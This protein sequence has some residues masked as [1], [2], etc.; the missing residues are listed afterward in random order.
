MGTVIRYSILTASIIGIAVVLLGL[1]NALSP[2]DSLGETSGD[3]DVRN[4]FPSTPN[5]TGIVAT[6]HSTGCAIALLSTQFTTYVYVHRAGEKD[7]PKSL[8]FRFFNSDENF[9]DP[10]IVWTDNSNVH[11]SIP[12][13][14]E[15]TKHLTS[16]DGVKISYAIGKEEFSR[17]E[18]RKY[19]I[20]LAAGL[21]VLLIF[22]TG[23]C[24][25]TVR[26]IRK[27]K[28]KLIEASERASR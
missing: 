18:D 6:G 24:F 4:D 14:G 3:C 15:V 19:T 25:L 1:F 27:Q 13:V 12:E 16:I 8:V 26:S 7:S 10:H 22:L 20:M 17:E 11:I 5:G 9:D 23:S 28:R 21:F 2:L